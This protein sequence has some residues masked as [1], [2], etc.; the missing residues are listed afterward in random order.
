MPP[1]GARGLPASPGRHCA[2]HLAGVADFSDDKE[3]FRAGY[4]LKLTR[5]EAFRRH[6]ALKSQ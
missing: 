1:Y 2:G 5:P 3:G 6:V 4:G